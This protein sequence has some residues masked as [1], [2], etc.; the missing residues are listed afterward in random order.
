MFRIIENEKI[1]EF[2][3]YLLDEEKSIAT[4][5]KYLYDVKEFSQWVAEK[6]LS[7]SQ[8]GSGVIKH[9]L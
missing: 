8:R 2:K 7:D 5:K 6:E 1:Q 3:Q 9:F 4:I